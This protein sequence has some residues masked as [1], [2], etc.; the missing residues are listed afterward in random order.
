MFIKKFRE[1]N[2]KI[3]HIVTV[4]KGFSYRP[5]LIHVNSVAEEVIEKDYFCKII[6]MET[7]LNV[8]D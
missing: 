2:G 4:P 3:N 8:E 1:K 7:L 6:D 5:I